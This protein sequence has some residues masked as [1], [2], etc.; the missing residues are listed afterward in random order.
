MVA[1]ASTPPPAPD[2]G[3]RVTP[4]RNV[5]HGVPTGRLTAAERGELEY[6]WLQYDSDL[7]ARSVHGAI[8]DR[9]RRDSPKAL[10]GPITDLLRVAGGRTQLRLLVRALRREFQAT[11]HEVDCSI[12]GLV[13]AKRVALEGG[14]R[15]ALEWLAADGEP[16]DHQGKDADRGRFDETFVRLLP[17]VAGVRATREQRWREQDEE[18]ERGWR[19]IAD[20]ET[21]LE[22]ATTPNIAIGPVHQARLALDRLAT[23]GRRH[24]VVLRAVYGQR[25]PS[26]RY[27]VFGELAPLIEWTRTVAKMVEDLVERE[28]A[29]VGPGRRRWVE[30]EATPANVV[31]EIL[32]SSGK[33]ALERGRRSMFVAKVKAEAKD[34]IFDA[35]TAYR[36][37]R[38]R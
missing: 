5:R 37:A 1:A 29:R 26:A 32:D 33:S 9:L 7:G 24:A 13:K 20:Q 18:I 6:L 23:V 27:D 19:M 34:M 16:L 31:R 15:A 14:G 4:T 28:L 22:P 12:G 35:D 36:E 11:R 25:S 30:A 8:E 17:T 2:S 10:A 3:P 21:V 38:A